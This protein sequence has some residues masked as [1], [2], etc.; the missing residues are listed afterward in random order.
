MSSEISINIG[1][2]FFI[3]TISDHTNYFDG[4]VLELFEGADYNIINLESPITSSQDDKIHKDGPHMNGSPLTFSY[5]KQLRTSLVTLA[6]NHILDYGYSGLA[7]TIN[8]CKENSI[9]YVGA[10]LSHN[11]VRKP[12]LLSDTDVK[13]GIINIAENEFSTPYGTEFG[14]NPLDT[15][16]NLKQIQAARELFDIVILI[17]H[18]GH[19]MYNLPSPRMVALY[20]YFA[21]CGASAV[22]SHHSHCISGYEIHHNVPIF[23][24]LGNF[25]FTEASDNEAW[26][27][28]LVLNLRVVHGNQLKWSLLPVRQAKSNFKLYLL[29]GAEQQNVLSDLEHYSSIIADREALAREWER[30]VQDRYDEVID[31]FSPLQMLGNHLIIRM[32]QRTGLSKLFRSRKHYLKMLNHLRCESLS[33]LSISAIY[34]YLNR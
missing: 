16:E 4:N 24:G 29:T 14:A 28:G 1:G 11:E 33:D 34:K 25:L 7:D 23:Y 13:I 21:E 8:K 27:T 6:N 17:V 12:F 5:L 3:N 2:D 26:Y 18:G 32:L 19:E 20:R 9:G 22:I 31:I 30:F 15:I 10:G